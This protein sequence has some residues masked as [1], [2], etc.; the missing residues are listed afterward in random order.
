[1][2]MTSQCRLHVDAVAR[3]CCVT[4]VEAV[5]VAVAALRTRVVGRLLQLQQHVQLKQNVSRK[6][7]A[8]EC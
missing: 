5:R 3:G 6:H 7:F 8:H 1:M 4:R 2:A